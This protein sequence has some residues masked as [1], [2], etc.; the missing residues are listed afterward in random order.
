AKQAEEIRKRI[1]IAER[2]REQKKSK[3][4][5]SSRRQVGL[6][7]HE[8]PLRL[9]GKCEKKPRNNYCGANRA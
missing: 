6:A 4:E 7:S 5:K 9:K 1:V 2:R 8:A 3:G